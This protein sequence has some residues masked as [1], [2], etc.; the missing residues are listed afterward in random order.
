MDDKPTD[1]SSPEPDISS[2]PPLPEHEST[3]PTEDATPT[4]PPDSAESTEP[5]PKVEP[6][7]PT[8]P[9]PPKTH[10]NPLK[11]AL[12]AW[13]HKK[14]WTW[15]L[16][17]VVILIILALVPW[18]RYS[19]AGLVLKQTFAVEVIDATTGKPVS[20]A[21]VTLD[22]ISAMT[23]NAG[24]AQLHVSVGPRQL[25]ISKQYYKTAV[26]SE[27]VPILAQKAVL[28]VKLEATGRQ[29]PIVVTNAVNGQPVADALV[30]VANTEATTDQKGQVTIVLPANDTQLSANFSA[31]SYNDSSG[32]IVVTAQSVPQN[33]FQLTPA[34]KLYF[35]SQLSGSMDVVKTNLDGTGRQTVLAGTGNEST[36]DTVLMASRDW[37][38]LALVS[39]RLHSNQPQLYLINTTANDQ[40][41]TIDSSNS[42]YNPVGWIGDNFVY[43]ITRN[44]VQNWQP[45]G[46][47][48]KAYNAATGKLTVLDQSSGSGTDISNYA[49]TTFGSTYLI[50][51]SV[52]YTIDWNGSTTAQL[53]G[54]SDSLV[55]I[56]PDGSAKVDIKDFPV[57]AT[58]SYASFYLAT[59][60]YA[61]PSL[62][63]QVPTGSGSNTY[64]SLSSG[65]LTS[66]SITDSTFYSQY[67]TYISS[68]DGT[69]TFWSEQ[70][71]SKNT[72]FI[73]DANGQNG[74]QIATLSDY[75]PYGWFSDNYLLVSKTSELYVMSV[76]GGTALKVTDY[77]SN[78]PPGYDFG[79][80]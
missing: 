52:I 65:S 3:Q 27:L 18:T 42:N 17:V 53:S 63:I 36:T 10:R 62:Y 68:P 71:D 20:S 78:L 35:L 76:G 16:S 49:N 1:Y 75:T 60:Q 15:P 12:G 5:A 67:P 43:S 32:T 24:L 51:N 9:K 14:R 26:M 50:N 29:V 64:Y 6:P 37:K 66:S 39:N 13:W 74:K 59:S 2:A 23:S 47:I 48:L 70:R 38:Y 19:L 69:L 28:I 80:Q 34:G 44:G 7:L 56:K 33:H 73:G 54:K 55:S 30:R 41:S 79:G 77:F 45:A 8:Y 58:L 21:S 11:R 22:H 4:L 57:P 40:L 46:Q 72:L 61:L 25:S 31:T